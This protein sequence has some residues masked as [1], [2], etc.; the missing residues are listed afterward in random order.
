MEEKCHICGTSST[1]EFPHI[2]GK[3]CA[4][5]LSQ[6]IAAQDRALSGLANEISEL[7]STLK[8][9]TA[10]HEKLAVRVTR[11][12]QKKNASST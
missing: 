12:E 7:G 2:A 6:R 10:R 4:G 9:L 1:R 5:P 3:D 11:L 8:D